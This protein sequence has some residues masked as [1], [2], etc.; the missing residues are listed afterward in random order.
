[1]HLAGAIQMIPPI[2]GCK[3]VKF[4]ALCILVSARH[5]QAHTIFLLQTEECHSCLSVLIAIK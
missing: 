1:M 5:R 2:T 3:V 4:V